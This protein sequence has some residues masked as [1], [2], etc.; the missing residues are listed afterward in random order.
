MQGVRQDQKE[1]ILPNKNY[2]AGRRVEYA[3]CK[4]GRDRGWEAQR[5]AG[6][7]GKWD[8]VW[9]RPTGLGS[10]ET[11]AV[12]HLK[13]AGWLVLYGRE[14]M[15]KELQT[16]PI[17]IYGFYKF[18]KGVS[19][20]TIWVWTVSDVFGQAVFIQVKRSKA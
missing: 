13:S 19:K 15:P 10:V 5:S 9:F 18:T 20:R 4:L 6:S 8:C 17:P 14:E 11:L 3:L 1:A 12:E 2:L 7:H 16:L